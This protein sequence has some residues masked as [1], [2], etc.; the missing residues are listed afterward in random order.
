MQVGF[1]GIKHVFKTI[2][3]DDRHDYYALK[4]RMMRKLMADGFSMTPR[5]ILELGMSMGSFMLPK[6][7]FFVFFNVRNLTKVKAL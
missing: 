4:E 7:V 5:L 2:I 1:W 3:N 6:Q